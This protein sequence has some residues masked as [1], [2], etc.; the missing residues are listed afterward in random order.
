MIRRKHELLT[1]AEREILFGIPTERDLLA[2]LYTFEPSDIDIIGA[3][4]EKRN[5]LGA[6]LQLGL[7]TVSCR[8]PISLCHLGLECERADA[9]QI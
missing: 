1:D 8:S 2:R 9:A 4:R 7:V 6:A 5:Q 3:R